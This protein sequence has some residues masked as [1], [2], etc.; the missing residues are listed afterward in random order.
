MSQTTDVK[1]DV[2]SDVKLE[3]ESKVEQKSSGIDLAEIFKNMGMIS[4]I[5][6]II[7]VVVFLSI[8]IGASVFMNTGAGQ[9][10]IEKIPDKSSLSSSSYS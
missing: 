9:Q 5:P 1:T 8:I 10:L 2:S 4:I 6:L 7:C 3:A